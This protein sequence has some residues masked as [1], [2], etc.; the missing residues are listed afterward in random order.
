MYTFK[1]SGCEVDDETRGNICVRLNVPG[2]I[3]LGVRRR[4]SDA[5]VRVI[6]NGELSISNKSELLL[7]DERGARRSRA[8]VTKTELLL[9]G[10]ESLREQGFKRSEQT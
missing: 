5:G 9:T 4:G 10:A 6:I 3:R 2:S 8:L 7:D 1:D